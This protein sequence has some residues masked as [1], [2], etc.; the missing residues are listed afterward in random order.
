VREV[1]GIG[2]A[3]AKKITE[4]VTTGRL[5]YYERLKAEFPEDIQEIRSLPGVGPKTAM[6]LVKELGIRSAADLETAI[7]DGRVA[8][9]P[10]VGEK[11]AAKMLQG[12]QSRQTKKQCAGSD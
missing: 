2:E 1:E 5:E 8:E 4:L 7:L 12:L 10:H 11:A 3:L 9:L 6:R